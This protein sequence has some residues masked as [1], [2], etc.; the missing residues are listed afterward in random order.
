MSGRKLEVAVSRAPIR[1]EQ[2]VQNRQTERGRR[3]AHTMQRQQQQQRRR[4]WQPKMRSRNAASSAE[5]QKGR[6]I[7]NNTTPERK[8]GARRP[9]KLLLLRG[10]EE[11]KV[12]AG[13]RFVLLLAAC[14][15]GQQQNVVGVGVGSVV[16]SSGVRGRFLGEF[17]FAGL[18]SLLGG[19]LWSERTRTLSFLRCC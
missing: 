6:K 2:Q 8:K 15:V 7:E 13:C 11:E 10:E 1:A 16:A 12:F 5:K 14:L 18:S 4:R 3:R 17:Y 19:A 9:R